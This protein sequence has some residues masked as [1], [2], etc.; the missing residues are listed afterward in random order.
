MALDFLKKRAE[1]HDH[2]LDVAER[3]QLSEGFDDLGDAC[4]TL[5]ESL[6][7]LERERG[8]HMAEEE[9]QTLRRL[10]DALREPSVPALLRQEAGEEDGGS[11]DAVAS[12]AGSGQGNQTNHHGSLLLILSTN[13]LM[14]K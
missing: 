12:A 2:P 1:T 3:Y 7:A 4:R 6:E 5:V 14:S 9:L 11:A 10:T 13:W 8:A